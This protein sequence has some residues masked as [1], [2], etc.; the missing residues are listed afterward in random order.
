MLAIITITTN[1]IDDKQQTLQIISISL[2]STWENC[3]TQF[4]RYCVFKPL[5]ILLHKLQN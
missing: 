1:E 4:K 5:W 2:I 3:C